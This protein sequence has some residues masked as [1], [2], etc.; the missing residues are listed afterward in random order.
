M[1]VKYL[2]VYSINYD[3]QPMMSYTAKMLWAQLKFPPP[4]TLKVGSFVSLVST[5]RDLTIPTQRLQVY[6][7][8]GTRVLLTTNR[9]LT[10]EMED[11]KQFVP[12]LQRTK[13]GRWHPW[14]H[15]E[16]WGYATRDHRLLVAPKADAPPGF[17]H[18][19]TAADRYTTWDY[20]R[21]EPI[22]YLVI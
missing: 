12:S 8:I 5:N 13:T 10:S 11:V 14:H 3:F 17:E 2:E 7:I 20:G 16:Q 18:T 22:A 9:G 6:D 1:N 15:D 4:D 19:F 21:G